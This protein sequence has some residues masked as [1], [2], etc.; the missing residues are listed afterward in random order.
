[1]AK[2]V[3]VKEKLNI[4]K[5]FILTKWR[6]IVTLTIPLIL[7]LLT[8]LVWFLAFA[9][10]PYPLWYKIVYTIFIPLLFIFNYI[11]A[12]SFRLGFSNLTGFITFFV[13]LVLAVYV[14]PYLVLVFIRKIKDE[15]KK[16]ND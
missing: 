13:V 14:L 11:M 12:L 4:K 16:K 9:N 3:T 7:F 10:P 1:M 5:F 6:I 8:F 2:K 15:N